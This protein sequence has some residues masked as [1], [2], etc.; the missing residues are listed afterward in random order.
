MDAS[1]AVSAKLDAAV[2]A[3]AVDAGVAAKADG[4]LAVTKADAG[5]VV[6]PRPA[7]VPAE[8]KAIKLALDA[9]NWERDVD[10]PGSFQLL[11]HDRNSGSDNVFVFRYGYEDAKAPMDRDAYKKWLGDQKH[12]VVEVDRQGGAAWYLQGKDGGGSPAFLYASTFGGR[13][14]ICG[15]SLYKDAESSKLGEVRDEVIKQAKKIC[16]SMTL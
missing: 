16:E 6:A 9:P 14:L 5:A 12:L 8:L 3:V 4:G 13:R 1:V 7:Q 15:G 11:V 10:S 2:V